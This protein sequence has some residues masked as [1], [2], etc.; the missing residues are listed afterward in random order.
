M[1]IVD[2]GFLYALLDRSD[3]WHERAV[4][5]APTV[6]EGW[7]TTWPVL[8]EATHLI[9]RR[10]GTR[11]ASAL[12]DEV[13]EGGLVAWDIPPGEARR[14]P[15]MMLRYQSLPMDLADASLVLVAN[16]LGHGRILTTDERDFGAYRWKNRQPF[17]NLLG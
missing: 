13:A 16:H 8:T 9:G 3:A 12:M 5:A 1:I 17:T 15:A 2:T 11:F 4:A 7:V 14:I 10:L 6:E